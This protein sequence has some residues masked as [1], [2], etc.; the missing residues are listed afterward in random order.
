MT[1]ESK[2]K[3]SKYNILW[4]NQTGLSIYDISASNFES[5]VVTKK[6]LSD[7]I[8]ILIKAGFTHYIINKL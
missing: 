2:K 1:V 4:G 6:E 7:K 3:K 5:E 8:K